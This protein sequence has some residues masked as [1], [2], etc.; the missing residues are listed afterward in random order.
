MRLI[1]SFCIKKKKIVKLT[2]ILNKITENVKTAFKKF[3]SIN[4]NQAMSKRIPPHL[5]LI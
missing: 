2:A 3:F 5:L 1:V 4:M